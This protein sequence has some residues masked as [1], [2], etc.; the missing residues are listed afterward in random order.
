MGLCFKAKGQ[1][2]MAR[3]Q[4]EAANGELSTMDG[5]K[6]NVCYELGSLYESMGD[7]TKAAEYYK[8][9]YQNDIGYKDIAQKIELLYE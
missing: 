9:I 8:L 6:K 7:K 3:D 4:L 5:V 1:F 2:D